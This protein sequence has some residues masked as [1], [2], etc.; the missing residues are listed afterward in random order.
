M[1]KFIGNL[2]MIYNSKKSLKKTIQTSLLTS[3]ILG[4]TFVSNLAAA[5]T[6]NDNAIET[7]KCFANI[8]LEAS[9]I[10]FT[11]GKGSS[12]ANWYQ[13]VFDLKTVKEFAFPDGKTTGVLMHKNDFIIEVFFKEE[14]LVAKEQVPQSS[15]DQ[16]QGVNKVGIF[17]NADLPQL[18]QCLNTIGVNATRIWQ[19]KNLGIDLLQVI[20]PD[21]NVLEI[22]SR[23][24]KKMKS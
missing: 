13:Q 9:L 12:L 14:L 22:V 10:A 7:E 6:V 24:S 19:D 21:G 16:W 5:N 15:A 18:K 11:A 20:D 8:E 23:R 4:L 2:L 3:F 1:I 17:S